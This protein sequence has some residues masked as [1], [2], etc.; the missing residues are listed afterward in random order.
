[1]ST[2]PTSVSGVPFWGQAWKLVVQ[3]ATAATAATGTTDSLTISYESWLPE[4]LRVTFEVAQVM[5]G[6]PVWYADISL[7]NLDDQVAQNILQNATWATLSAGFQTGPNVASIIWDGPVF[8]TLYSRE[9]VVDQKVTLHC[10]ASPLFL[11]EIVAFAVGPQASQTQMLAAMCAQVNAPPLSD[12]SGNPTLGTLAA[13]RMNAVQYPRGKTVFGKVSR[14]FSQVA[15]SN[16]VQNWNDGK[17]LYIS[18]L[19]SGATQPNYVFSPPLFGDYA[20]TQGL[21]PGTT[22]SI[23]GT[24]L[25]TPQGVVFTVLLDPRLKVQ[26]PPL[27]VQLVRTTVN[28]FQRTPLSGDQGA[29]ALNSNLLFF[30]AQV[31]HTGDTRGNE[32]TTE[33]TAWSATYAQTWDALLTAGPGGS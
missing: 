2:T 18:E 23:V 16:I 14:Y 25:Q 5:N 30:V 28:T 33:V 15:D 3:Y 19:T 29:A 4:A 1:M 13:Q 21:P 27:A 32:W 12:S 7:Y 20:Q 9:G 24:P 8:Q 11:D 26:L 17:Q 6:S 10:V 31:R 22:Q